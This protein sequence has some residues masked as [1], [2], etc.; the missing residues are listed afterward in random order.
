MGNGGER[1]GCAGGGPCGAGA[2]PDGARGAWRGQDRAPWPCRSVGRAWGT[3]AA[4]AWTLQAAGPF[5]HPVLCQNF[6]KHNE[7]VEVTHRMMFLAFFSHSFQIVRT[8]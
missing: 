5:S 7:K 4:A 3:A 8:L 2:A 6:Y 1:A